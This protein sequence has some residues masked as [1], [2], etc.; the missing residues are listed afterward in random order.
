[1]ATYATYADV[2]ARMSY[3]TISASSDPSTTEIEAWLVEAESLVF[4]ALQA[5][6]NPG[7]YSSTAAVASLCSWICDYAEGRARQS[8][9]NA[10]GDGLNV[11]DGK[12][13]LAKF[14][15]LID[16][17]LARPSLYG[18]RLAAGDAPATSRRLMSYVTNNADNKTVAAGDFAPVFTKGEV[19]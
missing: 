17:I 12:D 11:D 18:S 5:G 7:S 15:R 4:G 19:F 6:G 16:D 1:M 14:D 8:H 3:W 2:Q 10:R 13:L 9:A